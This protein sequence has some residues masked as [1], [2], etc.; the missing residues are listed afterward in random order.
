[1]ELNKHVM[2]D[3]RDLCQRNGV[4]LIYVLIPTKLEIEPEDIP[5]LAQIAKYNPRYSVEQ[6]QQFDDKLTEIALR[7]SAELGVQA[8][9]LRKPMRERRNGARLYYPEDMHL[10]VAG[11][12]VVA[13]ILSDNLPKFITGK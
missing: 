1:V 3:F 12:R 7:D 8:I 2:R 11:N 13:G 5:V 6:L 10:N 9:D 4:K